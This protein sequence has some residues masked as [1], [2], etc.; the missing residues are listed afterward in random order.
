MD[1]LSGEADGA[2]PAVVQVLL[3]VA[4]DKT[5]SYLAPPD[6]RLVPGSIVTVPLGTRKLIGAVWAFGDPAGVPLK[7]LKPVLG[8]HDAPALGDPLRTLVDWVARY[9]LTPRGMVL[10]MVLRVPE[11]LAPEPA[12][13]GV[14][15]AGPAPERLTD[16]RRR[17][18][19]RLEDGFAWTRTGLAAAAGTSPGVVDGLVTAGTLEVV[20]LPPGPPVHPP[21][22]DFNA[23]ALT[24]DQ[25]RA[26][27]ELRRAAGEGF[28]VTL[29]EGVTGAGKTDVYLEAVA[30]ALRRGRQ[31]LIL[32]PEIAL[33]RAFLERFSERFGANPAEWHSDVPPKQRMR[34]WRGVAEGRVPV[35]VGARSALFLPFADLGVIVVDEEH[36]AAYK[37]E[38]HATYHARDMAVVRGRLEEAAVVLSSATPSLETRANVERG[39]YRRL[40]LPARATGA[41]LPEIALIDMR[42]AGPEK[43]RFLAPGLIAA[44]RRTVEKGEQALLFLNRRGFAPLTLC[45]ACGHRFQCDNCST[46]LVD[47]RFRGT[48]SCHHCGHTVRRPESC[49]ACGALDS[50]VACGPGVER[51]AEEAAAV[52]PDKRIIVLSSDMLGGIQRLRAELQVIAE[53]GCDIVIGTQIVAKGHT[54]PKLTLVG[55]VDA[56]LGLSHGDPRAAERT[57]QLLVQVTGRAG[58]LGG[59]GMSPGFGILQ[60]FAPEHPVMAALVS[61]D[62]ERFYATEMEERRAASMPPFGRLAAVIVSGT[63]RPATED[64]ARALARAAPMAEGIEVL[65]PADAPLALVRGRHRLRLLVQSGRESDLSAYLRAWLAAAPPARGSLAVQVD[66]D[67]QSFL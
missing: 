22:P 26:A 62:P 58:R 64:H 9:T 27:D 5:Y 37:Q 2:A 55:V 47:H 28:S 44:V 61:R 1:L 66:V 24:P 49:P 29:L 10:R 14:R 65:G 6:L 30:E 4:L 8:V 40:V 11:A 39:R 46:W 50:L 36:D 41:A 15:R 63:D 52:F 7:K 16:A 3:P 31:V 21:D 59:E 54:F 51:I 42:R 57:F 35:V 18:L 48:L 12:V 53:G 32:V 60:T 45:R 20:A 38:E 67:P 25:V 33:T 17:V 43:G 34:V 19:A 23:R 56:D 13:P